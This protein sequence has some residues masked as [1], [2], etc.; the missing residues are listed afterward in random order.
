MALC[1]HAAAAVMKQQPEP[2][3]KSCWQA[4]NR[5]IRLHDPD[6]PFVLATQH[7]F[8]LLPVEHAIWHCEDVLSALSALVAELATCAPDGCMRLHPRPSEKDTVPAS[9][10]LHSIKKWTAVI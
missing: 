2:E 6:P 3:A 8:C 10:Y 7:R 9:Q 5:Y 4:C 1:V